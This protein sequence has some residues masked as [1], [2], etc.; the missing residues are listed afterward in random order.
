VLS[1]PEIKMTPRTD[2]DEYL[3]LACDGVWDVFSNDD[4]A[5]FVQDAMVDHTNPVSFESVSVVHYDEYIAAP[6]LTPA[7]VPTSLIHR[8]MSQHPTWQNLVIKLS[9]KA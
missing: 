5:V 7:A 4:M 3:I 1:T 8:G 2:D 6:L 9:G